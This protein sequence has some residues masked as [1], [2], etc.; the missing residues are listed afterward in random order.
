MKKYLLVITFVAGFYVS[1]FAQTHTKFS[2]GIDGGVPVGEASNAYNAVI[3]GSVK[4]EAPIATN[5]A[6]TISAGYSA[7]LG[8]SIYMT[9]G[10][11][12]FFYTPLSYTAIPVKAG[13]K[14]SFTKSFYAEAQLGAAIGL[15]KDSKI[16]FAYS[17]G[18]GYDFGGV[19]V[20]LR[21]EG[22]AYKAQNVYGVAA[23]ES[24]ASQIAARIGFRF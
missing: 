4:L 17:P 13:L 16:G 14:Y 6:F 21:Y 2:V 7:F 11:E 12:A 1:G 10:D 15:K 5:T 22:W 8:K 20:G 9:V 18:V 3:G 24:T 23:T 19:D